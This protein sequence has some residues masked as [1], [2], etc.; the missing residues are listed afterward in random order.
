MAHIPISNAFYSFSSVESELK[1]GAYIGESVLKSRETNSSD[2][3]PKLP[4]VLS[5]YSVGPHRSDFC[6]LPRCSVSHLQ[7]SEKSKR[8]HESKNNFTVALYL[9]I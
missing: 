5:I 6:L 1:K 2:M 4:S 8:K 9:K 3:D 7:L